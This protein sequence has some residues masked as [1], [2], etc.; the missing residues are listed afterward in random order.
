MNF[1]IE[2]EHEADG[3]WLA[4]VPELPGVMAYGATSMEAMSRVEVLALRVIADRLENNE[5]RPFE[6]NITI[7]IAASAAGHQLKQGVYLPL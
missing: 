5:N 1:T 3:R 4:G 7:P 2:Q 6:I